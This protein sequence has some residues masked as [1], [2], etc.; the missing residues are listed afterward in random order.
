MENQKL[1]ELLG[2]IEASL[3]DEQ[4]EKAKACKTREE[5]LKFAAD[6]GIALSDEMLEAVAGGHAYGAF[7]FA[8]Q[9]GPK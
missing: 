4:K 8:V 7:C 3:S 6:A 5:F 1:N 9:A 2:S